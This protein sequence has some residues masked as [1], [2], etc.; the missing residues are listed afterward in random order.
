M[1]NFMSFYLDWIF[2]RVSFM[3]GRLC[4]LSNNGDMQ[5]I[6]SCRVT[7]LMTTQNCR[8]TIIIEQ[9]T[10]SET[11]MSFF[12]HMLFSR[13]CLCGCVCLFCFFW[14]YP[15]HMKVPSPESKSTP[16]QWQH[17]I[18]N[19][20]SYQGTP[21]CIYVCCRYIYIHILEVYTHTYIY[22]GDFPWCTAS[23]CCAASCPRLT[24][25]HTLFLI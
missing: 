15:W 19:L 22:I 25:T 9:G 20:L 12:F 3:K 14:L 2:Q 11:R 23:F 6:S 21:A 17:Q 16:Q 10:F 7:I 13:I 1:K 18:L 24:Y 4:F 8:E 5:K